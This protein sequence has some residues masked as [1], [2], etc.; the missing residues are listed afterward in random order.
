VFDPHAVRESTKAA[1][2]APR[3][4]ISAKLIIR[5]FCRQTTYSASTMSTVDRGPSDH[6]HSARPSDAH[7]LSSRL[8]V[9]RFAV[10]RRGRRRAVAA[11]IH[12]VPAATTSAATACWAASV[13]L[14]SPYGPGKPIRTFAASAAT[15]CRRPACARDRD[16]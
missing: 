12:D 10:Q 15:A 4:G 6:D 16:P 11:I 2:T 9:E 14:R 3:I 7:L 8:S 5:R 1:V 13:G